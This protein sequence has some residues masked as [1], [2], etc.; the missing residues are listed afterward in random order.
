MAEASNDPTLEERIEL[1]EAQLAQAQRMTALGELAGTITHEF[2]NVLMKF[3]GYAQM[4][5]RHK[6]QATREHSF[7]K[8]V[9]V[10]QRTKKMIASILGMARNRSDAHEPTDL[11]Q[12]VED[13]LLLLE[14]EMNK[15]RV[16]VETNLQP[17]PKAL[18]SGNQIQQVLINLL[19]NARQAMPDGGRVIVKL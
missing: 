18:V 9:E 2:N 5:L 8:I 4:G 12:L 3:I 1:L 16:S 10:G 13:T 17:V 19:I 6:D 14:R 11:G 7:Q 15:Y